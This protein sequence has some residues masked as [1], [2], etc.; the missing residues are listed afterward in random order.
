[1]AKGDRQK[2]KADCEDGYTRV[3]NLILEALALAKLNGVQKGICLYLIR[4]SYGWGKSEEAISLHEFAVACG[5]S[6]TYIS[7]QMQDLLEKK[8]IIRT[9]YLP[10]K[11]PIYKLNT[12]IAEWDKGCIDVEFLS[13]CVTQGSCNHTTPQLTDCITVNHEQSH[14]VTPIRPA[15]NKDIKKDK[16]INIFSPDSDEYKLAVLLLER[17]KLHLRGFKEP[18]LQKWAKGMDAILRLDKRDVNEVRAVIDF[19]HGDSFWR[20]N[21]LST[22]KLRKNYDQLNAKRLQQNIKNK[23]AG[24]KRRNEYREEVAENDSYENFFK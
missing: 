24:V 13:G 8:I 14:K 21:I 12:N 10:G 6:K 23:G 18:D 11:K 20:S 1:M 2:L 16:E 19:A 22:D 5:T 9:E 3:A 7:K 15:L 17:I 4:Q